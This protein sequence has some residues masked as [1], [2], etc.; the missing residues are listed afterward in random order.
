MRKNKL[1]KI[2]CVLAAVLTVCALPP[3]AF[4]EPGFA[5]TETDIYFER[6]SAGGWTDYVQNEY[7]YG[8]EY[9][10][11]IFCV[12]GGNPFCWDD[13]TQVYGWE[14]TVNMLYYVGAQERLWPGISVED[15]LRGL[16]TIA[17]W[18]YPYY[19]PEGM[20]LSEARYAT[21]AAMHVYTALC[22]SDPASNGFGKSYWG[23][24]AVDRMRPKAGVYRS[25]EVFS[26]FTELYCRGLSLVQLPQS[27]SLSASEAEL[28]LS[29]AS[30]TGRLTVRL[31]NML[32]GYVIDQSCLD[33][34]ESLG[35]SISG[36][37]GKDGD[38]LTVTLPRKGNRNR[39]IS[40]SV[41]ASDPR[42][43]ADFG[44]VVSTGDPWSYQ[45]C[46]GFMGKGSVVTKSASAVLRTGNYGLP[47]SIEKASSESWTAENALYSL[48]GAQ[49]RLS[50]TGVDGSPLTEV[51]TLDSFG[52]ASGTA[53][54]AVGSAVEAAEIAAPAGFKT[55]ASQS[56]TVGEDETANVI[57]LS[58]DPVC[59]L[60][61][62]IIRKKD[63]QAADAQGN[64][65]LAGAEYS[66]QF[67][68]G[69]YAGAQEAEAS[70][71]LLR[72]WV[73]RTDASGVVLLD[74]EHKVTGDAF[75]MSGGRPVLPLGTLVIR[76]TAASE[77]YTLDEA[78][79]VMR[80]KEGSEPGT[81][82]REGDS[83]DAQGR[84]ESPEPVKRFG[85]RGV[86]LD[87]AKDAAEP[88]GDAVLS[89][90]VINV[91]NRSGHAVKVGAAVYQPGETVATITTAAN[92]SFVMTAQLPYGSYEL[93]EA[94]APAGYEPS[95]WTFGFS[96]S[97]MDEDGK[98][99]EVPADL[100]LK[101]D[102]LL[103]ELIIRKWDSARGVGVSGAVSPKEA[104][105]NIGF[106]VVNRSAKSVVWGGRTVAPGE[107]VASVR[108]VY[109]EGTG[110]Y[111]AALSGL[112]YGT[113][114]IRELTVDGSLANS[115]YLADSTAE[116]QIPLHKTG[117]QR[118]T[119]HDVCDTRVCSL[120]VS[121]TVSGNMGSKDRDFGFELALGDNRGVPVSFVKSFA[122]GSSESGTAAFAGGK[123][124]FSLK[125]GENIVFGNIV[126]G[127]SYRVTENAAEG[128]LLSWTGQPEGILSEDLAVSANNDRNAVVSTGIETSGGRGAASFIGGFA[129]T[130]ILIA[131]GKGERNGRKRRKKRPE[132][133]A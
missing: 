130:A 70:G 33:E 66:A 36:F 52:K 133:G 92:G 116:V 114:G 28:S 107:A 125:H 14:D 126:C 56:I 2:I 90:G 81:A 26:W 55:G 110:E 5:Y 95:S 117:A 74:E 38:V 20:S 46:V 111:R 62:G 94:A 91:I 1:K 75:Y 69:L 13:L 48:G 24:Y 113:Y 34:I 109:D 21:S 51:L 119:Y 57:S 30:F 129:G 16:I 79:Y 73:L 122:D 132:S 93:A 50:G 58:D 82:V 96:A 53:E 104:L 64:A 9:G 127:N 19:I 106:E 123:Y 43:D 3:G 99:F 65:S 54:F 37:T 128:Y 86:K 80:I 22:V 67:Y 103:Q 41:T 88:S 84:V 124:A 115:W 121:K 31:E 23:E 44:I 49:Y 100:A 59:S 102:P 47:V 118:V 87:A 131:T 72:S 15:Y 4:A 35:G 7:H 120:S 112:P 40:F 12:E 85:V 11:L 101:D 18:G 78:V 42:S 83:L 39:S 25:E 68:G 6:D 89:G 71:T 8:D 108:T 98:V 29:G 45:K 61:G 32:G 77:G 97:P 27:V 60:A 105:E 76:E 63:A 10:P 17:S